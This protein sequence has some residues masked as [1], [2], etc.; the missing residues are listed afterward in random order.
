LAACG[1]SA[2][3]HCCTN[4]DLPAGCEL[5]EGFHALR[6]HTNGV[7]STRE[8]IDEA[9]QAVE[10]GENVRA[11]NILS[12]ELADR[13]TADAY[14][15]LGTAYGNMK[16]FQ[17]AEDVF[18]EGSKRFSS[19]AR[20]LNALGDLYLANND[21]DA[22]RSVLRQALRGGPQNNH[23]SDLLATIGVPEHLFNAFRNRA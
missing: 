1:C 4:E 16:E 23:A 12:A 11:V 22:A 20:L 8:A 2:S 21:A 5:P 3:H 19:D 9:R 17:K 6:G 7:D 18:T 13:P 10:R 14:L 15:L